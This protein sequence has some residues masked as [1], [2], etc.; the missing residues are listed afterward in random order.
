MDRKEIERIVMESFGYAYRKDSAG[1][2]TETKIKEDLSSKSIMMVAL[3]GRLE[4]E[5]D[6]LISLPDASKMNTIGD[7]IDKICVMKGVE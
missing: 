6:V 3:V 5:L 7:M 4:D 1:L 2:S